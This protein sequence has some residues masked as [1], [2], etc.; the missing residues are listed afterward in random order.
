MRKSNKY[1]LSH[2]EELKPVKEYHIL[3]LGAGVQS[4]TVYLL[5][6]EGLITP[7]FDYAIFA[8]TQEEP[9]AVYDHLSWLQ[10]LNGPIIIIRSLGKLGEDLLV[11]RPPNRKS[12]SS[13]PT[14]TMANDNSIG[15][16][17]RQCTSDYKVEIIRTAI[18]RD[19]LKL[20]FK[21]L[22]P[23]NLKIFQYFGISSDEARRSV[24]VIKNTKKWYNGT[25]IFPLLNMD[26]TREDCLKY[27]KD[28][29]PHT[30]P[31]SACVFCPYHN[32]AE[33]LRLKQDPDSWK[34]ILEVDK[35]IRNPEAKINKYLKNPQFL[36]RSCVPIDEVKFNEREV[37]PKFT[38]EC[39]GMC[40]I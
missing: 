2:P 32:D 34:R 17:R 37:T 31:R 16:L 3:N 21:Q 35:I 40:G 24:N 18:K 26:W 5:N 6:M 38:Q 9:K 30:V 1:L 29:V 7:R 8:D 25:A 22:W 20:K 13:I 15:I 28:K 4:T 10:S 33:W 12:S 36:H 19:I 14:F 11:G 39:E 27:L 23:N